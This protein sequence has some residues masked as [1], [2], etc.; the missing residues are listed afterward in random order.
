[1]TLLRRRMI[2]DMKLKNLSARTINA[3]PLLNRRARRER[4]ESVL[5]LW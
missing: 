2:E 5:L 4:R 1:M 3:E